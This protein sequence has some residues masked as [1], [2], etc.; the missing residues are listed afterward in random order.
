MCGGGFRL[1]CTQ[2]THE[3]TTSQWTGSH[4]MTIICGTKQREDVNP[5]THIE[6]LDI[7]SHRSFKLLPD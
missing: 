6:L 5:L 3:S 4:Q 1:A 2:I 7:N